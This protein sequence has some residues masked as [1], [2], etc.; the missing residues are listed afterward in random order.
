MRGAIVSPS[1]TARAPP[2]VKS[3]W[4]S[5]MTSARATLEAKHSAD[6]AVHREVVVMPDEQHLRRLGDRLLDRLVELRGVEVLGQEQDL[7]ATLLERGHH[8]VGARHAAVAAADALLHAVQRL[9]LHLRGVAIDDLRSRGPHV[10]G[11][12]VLAVGSVPAREAPLQVRVQA[13]LDLGDELLRRADDE[14]IERAPLEA[15]EQRVER[16]VEMVELLL[17][18]RALEARLRPAALVVLA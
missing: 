12:G 4:K 11:R 14:V 8:R 6:A 10:G 16:V 13:A 7:D 1:R 2:G 5:T 17:L 18:D 9:A 3:F 15:L